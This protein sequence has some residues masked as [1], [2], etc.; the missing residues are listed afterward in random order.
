MTEQELIRMQEEGNNRTLYLMKVGMFFHAY[1]AGAFALA[2]ATGYRIKRKSRRKGTEV[3][4]AGFP[5][6]ALDKIIPR[7]EK[8]GG[9]VRKHSDIWIEITGLDSTA[10]ETL[11]DN[12]ER[13]GQAKVC[14]A[15]VW[16]Q[17]ILA[18][19]L[20]RST[21]LEAMNFLSEI[22]N[23]LRNKTQR[24]YIPLPPQNT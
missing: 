19:D 2:R 1:E 22:Q 3:L 14:A 23:K 6:N 9:T 11:V 16:E 21:P 8:A 20:T 17:D 24:R 4:T 15:K 7:L 10:D 12:A 18:F 5:A 13:T